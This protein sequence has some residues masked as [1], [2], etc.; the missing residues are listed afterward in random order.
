MLKNTLYYALLLTLFLTITGCTYYQ[1][2]PVYQSVPVVTSTTATTTTTRTQNVS[3]Y[4]QSWSAA[5]GAFS[6]NDININIQD[7]KVGLIQG[8]RDGT[9]VSG[10]L[11]TLGDGSVRV[12]FDTPGDSV[13]VHDITDSYN[14]RMGR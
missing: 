3:R 8:F 2:A 7:R 4:D 9:E 10:N 12:Q 6:D 14:R 5:I 11:R 1:T 13:L